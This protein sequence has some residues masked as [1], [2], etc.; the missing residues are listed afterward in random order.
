MDE[1]LIEIA[2]LVS[3]YGTTIIHEGLNLKVKRGETV[4]IVGGSGSGK[5]TLFKELLLLKPIAGGSLR[6]A[7]KEIDKL[8]EKEQ[9][10][11][12]NK[13]GVLFQSAALFSSL[14]VGENIVYTIRKRF[15][16]NKNLAQY[17]AFTKLKISG[18]EPDVFYMY[19]HELS[20]GMKKKAGLAR[21]LA[22]D[23]E[24][25][26]LDEP[27]SGLDPI[28]AD[29]FD[30]TIKKISDILNLTVLMITHDIASLKIVDTVAVL[31]NKKFVY[32]GS[33]KRLSSVENPW[34]KKYIGGER[35][36]VLLNGGKT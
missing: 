4:A 32:T 13:M 27:T 18:L 16:I 20:G 19:P 34:I 25:L 26:F 10:Q 29:E 3:K 35:G 6:I 9:Q 33:W 21:A 11:I 36:K 2:N 5:T 12:R 1:Y 8:S 22:L 30:R 23:P 17:I 15:K 7:G 28:S 14:T 31:F 24:I